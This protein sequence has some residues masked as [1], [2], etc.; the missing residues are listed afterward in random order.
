MK[1]RL[2]TRKPRHVSCAPLQQRF[3]FADAACQQEERVGGSGAA[4]FDQE[5][6]C[7]GWFGLLLSAETCVLFGSSM[8]D[9]K[10]FELELV[11]VALAFAYWSDTLKDE[12]QVSFCDND[13]VRFALIK[14]W[15]VSAC[16]ASL[17]E[18][19]SRNEVE[20]NARTWYARVPAEANVSDCLSRGATH[21]L[22]PARLECSAN[23]CE[24]FFAI[25]DFLRGGF[26]AFGRGC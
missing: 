15:C 26:S 21:P 20:C 11:A 18:F 7:L 24:R 12:L 9:T 22:L 6:T 17:M 25:L 23:V 3:V 19:H 4:L 8:K 2:K 1:Q 13:A 14:G 10:I 5:T 16:G